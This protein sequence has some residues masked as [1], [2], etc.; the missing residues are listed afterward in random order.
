M[1]PP[2]HWRESRSSA[3]SYEQ[4]DHEERLMQQVEAMPNTDGLKRSLV[5]TLCGYGVFRSAPPE[6]CPMCQAENAW[7]HAP[8]RSSTMLVA[9]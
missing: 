9:T 1:G 4:A 6:R 2:T 3:P 5:C 8:R 7:I